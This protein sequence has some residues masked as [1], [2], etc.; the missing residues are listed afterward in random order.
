MPPILVQTKITTPKVSIGFIT[1]LLLLPLQSIFGAISI[2]TQ[3]WHLVFDES[4][5]SSLN[6]A[7]YLALCRI[8]YPTFDIISCFLLPDIVL[9]FVFGA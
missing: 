1:H 2:A 8:R 6:D 3:K 9:P 4:V 7:C 5:S